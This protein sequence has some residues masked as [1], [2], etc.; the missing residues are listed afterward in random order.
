MVP[1]FD[2]IQLPPTV[3]LN[4]VP[5]IDLPGI[6]LEPEVPGA[7]AYTLLS[8]EALIEL[9][10]AAADALGLSE[11]TLA[12]PELL[13]LH[14]DRSFVAADPVVRAAADRVARRY[15]RRLGYLL[16]TLKRGDA[17]NRAARP[18]WDDAYWA[19]WAGIRRVWL[20]GGIM[21]GRLGRRVGSLAQ[22]LLTEAGCGACRLI[23]P[24]YPA[25][26]PLIGAARSG[27]PGHT[28]AVVLDFG[29]SFVKR[30]WAVYENGA[31]AALRLLPAVPT[32]FAA[33]RSHPVPDQIPRV[34]EFM[35]AVL[36]QT[37]RAVAAESGAPAPVLVVSIAAYVAG[38]HPVRT[39]LGAYAQLCDLTPNLGG[40]LAAE[41]SARIDRSVAVE[42]I[43]DGTAAARVYAG[44]PHSAV[45]VLGTALGVG[46]P[47]P[48]VG[49]RPVARGFR[50][51]G[52]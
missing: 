20:G 22:A 30:A 48:A 45:I 34:A 23:R 19:Y 26:L 44:Q 51:V 13:P 33:L 8:P 50:V 10:R 46:F 25:V 38:N 47:P 39:Q 6:A 14:F 28:A 43:H 21:S 1:P 18:E 5:I 35:I 36:A 16:L 52:V 2:P 24:R 31:L 41:S 17:V 15:A 12:D 9:V 29:Q 7:R 37:W 4:R 3:S 11:D 49:L 40:W 27:P 42:L 32:G